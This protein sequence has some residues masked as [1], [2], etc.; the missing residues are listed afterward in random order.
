MNGPTLQL[1]IGGQGQP[2]TA[3][4]ILA[5]VSKQMDPDR[6]ALEDRSVHNRSV[7]AGS[8]SSVPPRPERLE[9]QEQYTLDNPPVSYEQRVQRDKKCE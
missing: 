5:E 9:L 6:D 3:L 1:P 8:R 7:G 4:G 2:W